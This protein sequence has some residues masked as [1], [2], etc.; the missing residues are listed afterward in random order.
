M[1]YLQGEE[2]AGGDLLGEVDEGGVI[3]EPEGILSVHHEGFL[4]A[5]TQFVAGI[6]EEKKSA[7]LVGGAAFGIGGDGVELHGEDVAVGG[8]GEGFDEIGERLVAKSEFFAGE[9]AAAMAAGFEEK[10]VVA[11]EVVFFGFVDAA[12]GEGNAA[13]GG[14]GEGGDFIVDVDEGLVEILGAGGGAGGKGGLG[15]RGSEGEGAASGDCLRAERD[16]G[17]AWSDGAIMV[18]GGDQCTRSSKVF[19]PGQI[20]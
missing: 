3:A 15:G 1:R 10:D 2:G 8:P 17:M 9:E 16:R 7:G 20:P 18:S 19:R 5:G 6:V 14:V 11:L 13:I 12:D 4:A